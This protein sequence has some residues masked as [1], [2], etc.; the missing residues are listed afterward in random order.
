MTETVTVKNNKATSGTSVSR[1]DS[2]TADF[3]NM[4]TSDTSPAIVKK[5]TPSTL[6]ISSTTSEN[7]NTSPVLTVTSTQ[8]TTG[9][10]PRQLLCRCP[11]KICNTKWHFLDGLD[12]TDSE[13]IEIILEDFYQNILSEITI[14]KTS[15]TKEVRKRNSAVNKTGSA[16]FI[17]SGCIIFLILP[18]VI[19]IALDL[20]NCCFHLQTR[21]RRRKHGNRSQ[22]N[23][24]SNT[25]HHGDSDM[26]LQE[27]IL[28]TEDYYA[29]RCGNNFH[30][31]EMKRE[32]YH[33]RREDQC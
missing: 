11:K 12:I 2:P 31:D 14:D 23:A 26:P 5:S 8:T 6:E 7:A 22:I 32:T 33:K 3:M 29:S 9:R 27:N 20:L 15:V 19:L 17:G 25:K 13:V 1:R 30:P 18:I 16:K 10:R 21:F 28:S 24:I 4:I